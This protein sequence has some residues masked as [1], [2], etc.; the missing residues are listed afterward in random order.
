MF[1]DKKWNSKDTTIS[2]GHHIETSWMLI[3]AAKVLKNEKL[4]RAT[5][6][7]AIQ[8]VDTFMEETIDT[9]GGVYYDLNLLTEDLNDDK[10]WWPQAEAIIGLNYAYEISNN[11]KYLIMV[12]K[13]WTFIQSNIIDPENG[14]WFW[15]VNKT[16]HPYTSEYK[17]GMWKAPYHNS[18]ACM[19]LIAK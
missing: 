15:R 19:K 16:G 3:D 5:N 17:V 12:N 18:R 13:I 7:A 14:E 2:F 6:K 4:K 1:F 9:D 11:K 10:H 8:I